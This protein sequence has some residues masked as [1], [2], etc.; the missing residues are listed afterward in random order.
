MKRLA[1]V[2]LIVLSACTS[3]TAPPSKPIGG[4]L[5]CVPGDTVIK[6]TTIPCPHPFIP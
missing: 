2:V 5:Y 1:I 3:P 6:G 4:L